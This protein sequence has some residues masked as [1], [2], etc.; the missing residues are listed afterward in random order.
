MSRRNETGPY[1]LLVVNVVRNGKK[2][3]IIV[4]RK[5]IQQPWMRKVRYG[6]R[7]MAVRGRRRRPVNE[8]DAD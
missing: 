3:I 2:L 1:N 7:F 6:R 5:M 4:V 8:G